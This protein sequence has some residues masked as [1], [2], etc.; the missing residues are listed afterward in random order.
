MLHLVPALRFLHFKA[1][2]TYDFQNFKRF[3]KKNRSV[4][5]FTERFFFVLIPFRENRGI[6]LSRGLLVLLILSVQSSIATD[7]IPV[8]RGA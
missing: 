3:P 7:L 1:I 8:A 4:K 6:N 2:V 5:K